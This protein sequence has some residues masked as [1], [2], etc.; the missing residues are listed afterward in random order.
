MEKKLDLERERLQAEYPEASIEAWAMDEHRLGLKPVQWRVWAQQAE[1]PIAAFKWRFQW[2]W[3]YGFVHP[4]SGETKRVDS[5]SG[6]Y[7]VI[8]PS[9]GR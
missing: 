4:E 8:Q 9:F 3:L 1:P 7:R 5:A 6:Q 2:L